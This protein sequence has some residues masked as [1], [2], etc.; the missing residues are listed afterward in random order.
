MYC[1]YAIDNVGH[2][3]KLYMQSDGFWINCKVANLMRFATEDE[4]I[5]WAWEKNPHRIYGAEYFAEKI[6]RN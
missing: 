6:G 5:D 1:L 3:K 4:A 2:G